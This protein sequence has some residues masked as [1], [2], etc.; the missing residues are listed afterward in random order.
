V[1]WSKYEKEDKQNITKDYI[2]LKL[3]IYL[4]LVTGF[5]LNIEDLMSYTEIIRMDSHTSQFI[6]LTSHNAS[7]P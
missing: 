3:Y 6:L 7:Y 2:S 1:L 5:F 4:I